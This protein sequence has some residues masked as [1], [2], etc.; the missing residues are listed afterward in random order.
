ML[1]YTIGSE[2][3]LVSRDKYILVVKEKRC[4]VWIKKYLIPSGKW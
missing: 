3:E 1:A 4:A 2:S